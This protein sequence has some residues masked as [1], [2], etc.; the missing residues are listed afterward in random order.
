MAVHTHISLQIIAIP[1]E[2]MP[3]SPALIALASNPYALR[4]F[5]PSGDKIYSA[6]RYASRAEGLP[7]LDNTLDTLPNIDGAGVVVGSDLL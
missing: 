6:N 5:C 7:A 2:A 1:Q 4:I 3:Y